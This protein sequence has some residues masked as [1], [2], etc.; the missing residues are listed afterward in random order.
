MEI[1][2]LIFI[3]IFWAIYYY[4][5]AVHDGHIILWNFSTYKDYPSND[6]RETAKKHSDKWHNI[7][8]ILKL[9][10]HIFYNIFFI[11]IFLSSPYIQNGIIGMDINISV[12]NFIITF[13][14]FFIYSIGI[15]WILMDGITNV[16]MGVDF[17]RIDV[18]SLTGNILRWL[19]SKGINTIIFK[20]SLIILPIIGYILYVFL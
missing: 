16:M 8:A 2:L 6:E 1:L 19:N 13:I 18:T 10:D 11:I 12:W 20:I 9:K 15:R 3:L 5:E 14:L 7:D 17:W 4:Y